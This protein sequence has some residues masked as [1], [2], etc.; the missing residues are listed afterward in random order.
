[1]EAYNGESCYSTSRNRAL[2]I[3][4]PFVGS[5]NVASL[6]ASMACYTLSP[7]FTPAPRKL[8]GS[9]TLH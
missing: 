3:A 6:R 8:N 1:M 9:Y 4:C 7:L 5:D 2:N